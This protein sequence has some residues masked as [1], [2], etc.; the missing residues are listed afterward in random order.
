MYRAEDAVFWS[1]LMA[2][3]VSTIWGIGSLGII[4]GSGLAVGALA[5]NRNPVALFLGALLFALTWGVLYSHPTPH[6]VP[7]PAWLDKLIWFFTIVG[8]AAVCVF[9]FYVLRDKLQPFR[10]V[11]TVV[12]AVIGIFSG[13]LIFAQ[14]TAK[15]PLNLADLPPKERIVQMGCLSCHTMDGKGHEEPGGPLESVASRSITTVHAFLADPT[16]ESAETLGIR[17]PATGEMA[18]VRLS[19]EEVEL[20]AEALQELFEVNPPSDLGP[21]AEKVEAI[22]KEKS[23]LDCHAVKGEGQP[24]GGLGGDLAQAAKHEKDV[25]VQW[26]MEP[27]AENAKE[28]GIRENPFG[29]MAAFALDQGQAEIV[30]DWIKTLDEEQ[31]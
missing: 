16:K 23:C 27:T 9:V 25:L 19:E 12:A 11:V 22:F 31:E 14:V 21:G 5:L 29:A 17:V 8:G 2:G 3:D 10:T 26:L 30:A 7:M 28:L 1:R 13:T 18:G 6:Y 15:E 24:N 4:A 20:L